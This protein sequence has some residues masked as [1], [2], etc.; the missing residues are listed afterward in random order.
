MKKILLASLAVAASA[1]M[2]AQVST[3]LMEFKMDD[4]NLKDAVSGVAIPL[5]QGTPTIVDGPV[6]GSKAIHFDGNTW[7]NLDDCT[8]VPGTQLGTKEWTVVTWFKFDGTTPETAKE[9][10]FIEVGRGVEP[11]FFWQCELQGGNPPAG[12]LTFFCRYG[13][14]KKETVQAACSNKDTEN[15]NMHYVNDGNWHMM[16]AVKSNAEAGPNWWVNIDG[17]NSDDESVDKDALSVE[18]KNNSWDDALNGFKDIRVPYDGKNSVKTSSAIITKEFNL[19]GNLSIG[20]NVKDGGTKQL[21]GSISS[22]TL[23]EGVPT[24]DQIRGWFKE[25]YPSYYEGVTGGIEDVTV[26]PV[27]DENAPMYN[28]QGVQ[29]DENYKGIVIKNGKKFINR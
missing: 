17:V 5:A 25:V 12:T 16:V 11:K 22:I 19:T 7:Y 21:V 3:K 23:Y 10:T 15:G 9:G 13:D 14:G 2:M 27:E 8:K 6:A 28:L 26:A 4:V 18:M 20:H 1:S 24:I 29:V